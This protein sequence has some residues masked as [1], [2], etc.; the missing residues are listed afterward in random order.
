M[1]DSDENIRAIGALGLGQ[2]KSKETIS[3]LNNALKDESWKVRLEAV[4]S[5]KKLGQM[6]LLLQQSE[7]NNKEI[8]E[9]VQ[10]GIQFED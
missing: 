1:D 7:K 2:Y 5:L 6:D 3:S 10:Y 4:R 9:A 8:Y